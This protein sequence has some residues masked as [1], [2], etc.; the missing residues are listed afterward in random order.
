[1]YLQTALQIGNDVKLFTFNKIKFK[2]QTK[3]LSVWFLKLSFKKYLLNNLLML[4]YFSNIERQRFFSFF[5]YVPPWFFLSEEWRKNIFWGAP[6]SPSN[7]NGFIFFGNPK[8]GQVT[9][10]TSIFRLILS[11]YFSLFFDIVQ[12]RLRSHPILT[13]PRFTRDILIKTVLIWFDCKIVALK[14]Q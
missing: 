8:S 4:F 1:M 7:V 6:S 5:V 9:Y 12:K 14:D 13:E 11:R 10:R 2:Q 3:R